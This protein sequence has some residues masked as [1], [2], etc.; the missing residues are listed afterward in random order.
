LNPET[1]TL[2]AI[3]VRSVA[4]GLF[5]MTVFTGLWAGIAYGGG[6]LHSP[7]RIGLIVFVVVMIWFV[8]QAFR[9][10]GIAKHYPRIQ[11]D[12]DAK[13]GKKMGMW[14]GI[15]FGAEGLFIFLA[16]NLVNNLGHPDLVIPAIALV[17]GLHFY[18][19]AWIFKRKIDYYLATGS[20]IVAIAAVFF[21]LHHTFAFET[22]IAFVG[23]G[24][25]MATTSY[26]LYMIS[27]GNKMIAA[28]PIASRKQ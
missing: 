13:E 15:I 16:I 3:A 2:P 7:Y 11:S 28:N 19:M 5:M 26:G 8:I 25:A 17:V 27:Y 21:I 1:Q 23:I 12:E 22:T 4:T 10:F 24:L 14:F 20:T 6:L 18:P 9:F